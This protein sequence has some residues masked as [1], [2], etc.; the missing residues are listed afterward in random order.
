M[1]GVQVKERKRPK[2]R[3]HYYPFGLCLNIDQN[4]NVTPNTKKYQGIELE[5]HFGLEQNETDNRINDSQLGIFDQSDEKAEDNYS[6]S[7]YASMDDN[8]VSRTDPLGLKT[9][10]FG[11]NLALGINQAVNAV[12][13]VGRAMSSPGS[14]ASNRGISGRT[15][16]TPQEQVAD[17]QAGLN[18]FAVYA[19]PMEGASTEASATTSAEEE[20]AVVNP[21]SAAFN[22][23]KKGFGT[24]GDA[25]E[26]TTTVGRW[27]SQGEY[28]TMQK[29]NQ[30]VEGA[31][32]QT[33]VGTGGKD[34]FT[35]APKGSVYAEF[36][37]PSK[38]L[39]QG[40]KTNWLKA[41]GPNANT[42]M[43]TALKKQ[44]GSTIFDFKVKD[45]S[46]I[47]YKK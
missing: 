35:S 16:F 38:N 15:N 32:G 1:E 2:N 7:P 6:L 30:M 34:A 10:W 13:T 29:T 21:S 46:E 42:A 22:E 26:E 11:T 9:G 12:A 40:G 20:S 4:N 25:K 36:K 8:P 18:V 47:L 43:K 14:A 3:N 33:F 37:V 23:V 24:F 28:K 31:G 45:L 44:G 41:I 39:L 17:F 5:R 19:L 27:M